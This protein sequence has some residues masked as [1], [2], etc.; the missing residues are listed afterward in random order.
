MILTRMQICCK[1][2]NK[3]RNEEYQNEI[4]ARIIFKLMEFIYI[5]F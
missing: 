5:L 4:I 1:D 2:F 3:V